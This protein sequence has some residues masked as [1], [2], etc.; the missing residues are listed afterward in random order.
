MNT[1]SR[2][3]GKPAGSVTNFIDAILDERPDLAGQLIYVPKY[4]SR[5]YT[6]IIGDEVFKAPV[7]AQDIEAFETEYKTLQALGDNGLPI[8]EVMHVGKKA[9]FYSM[10]RLSGVTLYDLCNPWNDDLTPKQKQD[11]AKDIADFIVGMANAMPSQEGGYAAHTDMSSANIMIDPDSKKFTG[12]IDFG[13][14]A[15]VPKYALATT[16]VF[17]DINNLVRKEFEARKAEIP[18]DTSTAPQTA[19]APRAAC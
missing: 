11:I 19:K 10:T 12:V 16:S 9:V 15:Y 17:G 8:P 3:A 1:F 13:I 18:D 4:G 2:A 6:V 14:T 5:A 7:Y